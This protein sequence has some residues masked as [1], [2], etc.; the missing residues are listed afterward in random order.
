MAGAE[1]AMALCFRPLWVGQHRTCFVALREGASRMPGRC[2]GKGKALRALRMPPSFA[3]SSLHLLNFVPGAPCIN[4]NVLT[5]AI[6][7]RSALST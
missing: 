6:L 3:S 5:K 2:S 4:R 1:A 7:R